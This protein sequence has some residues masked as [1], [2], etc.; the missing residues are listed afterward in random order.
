MKKAYLVLCLFAICFLFTKCAKDAVSDRV[1]VALT[2]QGPNGSPLSKVSVDVK[3]TTGALMI[4]GLTDSLGKV[5]GEVPANQDFEVIL[6][7]P[8]GKAV[9][10]KTINSVAQSTNIGVIKATQGSFQTISGKLVDCNGTPVK[11]GYASISLNG[12]LRY[13]A[14]DASG[15]FSVT[16]V[17]CAGANVSAHILGVDENTLQKTAGTTVAING[18]EI[19]LGTLKACGSS[20]EQ[21]VKYKLD[22]IDF[23]LS[24]SASKNDSIGGYT[25]AIGSSNI[26][27]ISGGRALT[28]SDQISFGTEG[29]NAE[30]T[31]SLSS[32][33]VKQ[34]TDV[35]LLRPFNITFSSYPKTAGG[36]YEGT[37][38]GK[39]S[40]NGTSAQHDISASFKVMRIN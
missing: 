38:S 1:K 20:I 9:Y 23:Q 36:F 22:G 8:C 30:G 37:F 16:L 10:S 11:N 26:V 14:T 19:N 7:D 3:T 33:T 18:T 32:L 17:S 39:F 31:F 28:N 12:M 25:T 24:R 6:N 34:Y 29:V 40:A 27:L 13:A 2:L 35:V 5:E 15:N 4:S 21:F